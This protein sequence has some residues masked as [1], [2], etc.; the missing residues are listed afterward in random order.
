MIAGH[1]LQAHR[2]VVNYAGRMII[3][4]TA[5]STCR[6]R[7]PNLK[8]RIEENN[9]VSAISQ[10]GLGNISVMLLNG[11]R[12]RT[13]CISG[14]CCKEVKRVCQSQ[15]EETC[16]EVLSHTLCLGKKRWNCHFCLC[17]CGKHKAVNTSIPVRKTA[18]SCIS[19]P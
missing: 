3:V 13:I 1:D 5:R 10:G 18:F 2:S 4:V 14:G 12:Q 15:S 19:R 8:N 11:Q 16:A 17:H 7:G 9:V 6:P